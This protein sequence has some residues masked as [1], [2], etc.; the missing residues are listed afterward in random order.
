MAATEI[1]L[2]NKLLMAMKTASYEGW[3][4]KKLS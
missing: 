4:L 3:S 1:M 2:C